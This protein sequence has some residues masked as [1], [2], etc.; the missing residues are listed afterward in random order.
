MRRR[1]F[2]L[3]LFFPVV[4]FI[5]VQFFSSQQVHLQEGL[6]AALMEQALTFLRNEYNILVTGNP[7]PQGLVSRH[8]GMT[9]LESSGEERIAALLKGREVSLQYGKRYTNIEITLN[10]V[11][12]EERDGKMILHVLDK[13]TEHF[14]YDPTFSSPLPNLSEESTKH[15]FIFSIAPLSA[16]SSQRPYTVQVGDFGYT[17]TE[18][19]TEPQ[20]LNASDEDEGQEYPRPPS[21]PL[22]DSSSTAKQEKQKRP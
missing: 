21:V 10:P 3:L 7:P 20:M 11:G 4:A 13:I 16:N 17:L 19:V 12:L 6:E 15:D 14:T 1:I 5:S 2:V 8:N 18:D 9:R 22:K